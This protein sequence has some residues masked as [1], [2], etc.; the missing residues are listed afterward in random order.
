MHFVVKP[1]CLLILAL[2]ATSCV[3]VILR[4]ITY[5]SKSQFSHLQ[6]TYNITYYYI[7]GIDVKIKVRYVKHL[8]HNR[9]SKYTSFLPL[10]KFLISQLSTNKN[11][12]I[13]F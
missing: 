5:L 1:T 13:F 11:S 10:F 8:A 12:I 7:N 2:P 9:Y 3:L 6:C 4:K